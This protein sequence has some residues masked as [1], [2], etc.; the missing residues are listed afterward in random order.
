MRH[1]DSQN[2][3]TPLADYRQYYGLSRDPF[4]DD[5]E[6]PF[7]SGAGRGALLEQ[8]RHLC[9][10]SASMLAVLAPAGAGKTRLARELANSFADEDEICFID[11]ASQ[12]G[13]AD[14]LAQMARCFAL[15]C[16]DSPSVGQL[17]ASLRHFAQHPDEQDRLALTLI[18]NAQYL[19]EQTLGALTSLLQGP[20]AVGRRLHIVLFAE[21]EMLT[22]LDQFNM[23]DV[24]IHDFELAPLDL[25][26]ASDYL[27][28]RMEMADYLGPELFDP[29]QI[30]ALWRRADGRLGALHREARLWLLESVAPS[31]ASGSGRPPLPLAHIVVVALLLGFLLM[32]LLYRNGEDSGQQ[33]DSPET[34]DEERLVEAPRRQSVDLGEAEQ[35]KTPMRDSR[36]T[37]SRQASSREK[38]AQ[39][40]EAKPDPLAV[41]SLTS[42]ANREPK[43]DSES[44]SQTG[45]IRAMDEESP[46][47]D[48]TETQKPLPEPQPSPEPD[49]P[50]DEQV[51]L[52][53]NASDYTLQLL[54][55]SSRQSVLD[56]IERQPNKDQLLS[57]ESRRQGKPWFVV[58]FGRY[59]SSEAARAAIDQLPSAQRQA[60]PWPRA[61]EAIQ[62]EIEANRGL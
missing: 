4:Q 16:D 50:E 3:E 18:D 11:A 21:P 1:A 55:A 40:R 23:H 30:E 9:Q 61:M 41:P 51:L 12:E 38:E 58:V 29:K 19:D 46:Q 35:E 26:E 54:G 33:A 59:A 44:S 17:L 22:R 48:S 15:P 13:A 36:E 49:L 56:Y 53:W 27:N 37:P 42:G 6:F 28:F 52:S 62:E 39:P 47:A 2:P 7:F 60:G 34:S 10:F 8:L 20:D 5:P 25:E 45:E 14:L 32:M 31:P 24:L 43:P 57:F